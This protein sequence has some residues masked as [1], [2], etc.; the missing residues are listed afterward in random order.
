MGRQ[1]GGLL[2]LTGQPDYEQ[3][4][5]LI[6]GLDPNTGE[7]LTA[8]LIEERVPGWDATASVPKGVTTALER[9]D[10][11]VRDVIWWAGRKVLG[12]LEEMATTRVRKGGRQEDRL[13]QNL[14]WYAKE[15]AETRPTKEDGMPDWDRHI[16]FVIANETFD[17]VETEWKAVKFRPIMDLKKWFSTRFDMYAASGMAD[18]GYEIET[19]YKS[20]GK[21]G[22]KYYTW[23][24]KG[25]PRSGAEEVQPPVAGSGRG[26]KGHFGEAEEGKQASHLE[27]LCAVARDKLGASS[28]QHK[29]K[30]MTLADYREYWHGRIT[31][32]EAGKIADTIERARKGLKAKPANTVDKAMQYALEHHFYR[33]S[34][35][36]Y[37]PLLITA[38]ER[39]MGA[40]CRRT[41]RKRRSGRA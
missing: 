37:K 40:A 13:T 21:G 16:H 1:G 24:I 19:K 41:W 36:G 18:L 7:Q 3:F 6:Q 32:E 11:R 38:M 10:E 35:Y 31:P 27:E 26:G 30:D 20:D 33:H 39:A 4:K 29:R 9:G 28:R 2:G 17:P 34:V 5:R 15:D 14:V 8:K 22:R 23:D 12:E 25:I